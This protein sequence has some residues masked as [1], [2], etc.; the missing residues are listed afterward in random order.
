MGALAEGVIP[1][2][3]ALAAQEHGDARK[4]VDTLYEAG[5]IAEKEGSATVSE[6]ASLLIPIK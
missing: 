5:R 6:E 1:K 3:A 2:V 4:A